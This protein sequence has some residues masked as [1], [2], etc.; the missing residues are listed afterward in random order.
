MKRKAKRPFIFMLRVLTA[1]LNAVCFFALFS[2]DNPFL[3]V[4][5][6][7]SLIVGLSFFIVY[8]LMANV[9]GGFDIGTRKSRSI[10]FSMA[11]VVFFSDLVAHLFMCIMDY[12]IV[13][14]GRFV[15]ERP[16]VLLAVIVLQIAVTTALAFGGNGLYFKNQP[17][18]H[19]LVIVRR[20]EPYEEWLQKITRYRKQFS[21]EHVAYTDDPDVF[22]QIELAD[23]V[24]VYNLVESERQPYLTYA[25]QTQKDFYYSMELS[26]VVGQGGEQVFFDDTAMIYAEA[27]KMSERGLVA[28]RIGDIFISLLGLILTSPILLAAAIAIKLEDG[29]EIFYRQQRAT[30]GG[31]AFNIVKF[32]SMRG[33]VGDVHRSVMS[34]DDRITRVGRV[35]RKYRLDEL[36]QLWNV[37][38][39]DMSVV[40]PRPEML[41]NV[42]KYTRDLPQFSYRLRAKAGMTGMAQVYGRYNTS[43]KDKLILDMLYIENFSVWLD[44]KLILRTVMVLFTPDYSTEAFSTDAAPETK[45]E[46][47]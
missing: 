17:P 12:T 5:N 37:L 31:R 3:L 25:Y 43:P 30:Y 40:G 28:K 34:D 32:R 22:R 2:L 42:Q 16:L 18:Q 39:G 20:G 36:P 10:V 46:R 41:E 44:M 15:Y 45:E 19:C 24:F 9:Y 21:V 47:P 26:D 27:D 7:T 23:T 13:N 29:G 1:V 4:F 38:V 14:N 8:I 6:R 33:D 35:L 11:M